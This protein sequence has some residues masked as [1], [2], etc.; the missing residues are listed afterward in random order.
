M[1]SILLISRTDQLIHLST[2]SDNVLVIFA[3]FFFLFFFS[4]MHIR[5]DGLICHKCVRHLRS[6]I[7]TLSFSTR[8]VGGEVEESGIPPSFFFSFFFF[9][10]D[11]ACVVSD[12]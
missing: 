4:G 3:G 5:H 7:V 9:L 1:L 12:R 11:L 2:H 8:G 6:I 10:P